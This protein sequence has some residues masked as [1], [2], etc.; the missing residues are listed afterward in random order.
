MK[1]ETDTGGLAGS[2]ARPTAFEDE[3]EGTGLR[4]GGRKCD[5][6][7]TLF[8]S[9]LKSSPW[10]GKGPRDDEADAGASGKDGLAKDSDTGGNEV[11]GGGGLTADGDAATVGGA[12]SL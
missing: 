5:Q 4:V 6:S 7:G 2:A 8:D 3:G 11:R 9:R 1:E 10:S 12:G